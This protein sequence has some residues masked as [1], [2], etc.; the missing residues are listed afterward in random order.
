MNQEAKGNAE[1]TNLEEVVPSPPTEVKPLEVWASLSSQQRD[2][3]A[4]VLVAAILDFERRAAE[5]KEVEP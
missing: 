4:T 1:Y 5:T 2:K 3:V